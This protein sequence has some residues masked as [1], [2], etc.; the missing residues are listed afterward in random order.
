M[1]PS[2]RH[3]YERTSPVAIRPTDAGPEEGAAKGSR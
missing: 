3:D 2:K 1:H